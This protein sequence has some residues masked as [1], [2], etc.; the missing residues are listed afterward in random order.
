MLIPFLS[1]L[2]SAG[3]CAG[4][5]VKSVCV[6]MLP[7]WCQVQAM[8]VIRKRLINQQHSHSVKSCRKAVSVSKWKKKLFRNL[9]K[10][11]KLNKR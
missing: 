3:I 10:T 9:E 2:L 5:V 7:F 1:A 8:F 4:Q 6:G 11:E